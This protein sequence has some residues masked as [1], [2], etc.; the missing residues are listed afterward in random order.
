M[1]YKKLIYT[2]VTRAKQRLIII[3]EKNALIKAIETNRED[4]RKTSLKKFLIDSI[5]F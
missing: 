2:A 1:L 3:G 4:Y 5:T